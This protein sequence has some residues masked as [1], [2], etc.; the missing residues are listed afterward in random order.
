MMLPMIKQEERPLSTPAKRPSLE[1]ADIFRLYGAE[2]RAGHRLSSKQRSVMFDIEHCRSEVFG[3]HA[4]ACDEC[5]HIEIAFNSCRNRHCPRC[6]GIARRKWVEA[7][8]DELLP[9]P[10]YHVVFTLPDEIFLMGL[11]NRELLYNLLFECAA[12]TLQAFAADPKHLGA[13]IGFY[14]ILHTW[15][16]TLWF[17]PHIH[18]IVIGGGLRED[19]EWIRPKYESRFLFPVRA[20]S[21]VFRGKFIEGLKRAYAKGELNFPEEMKETEQGSKF[22][23]WLNRLVSRNWVVYAKAPFAGPEEVV[24][25]IGRYTHRVA[26]SNRRLISID[27]GEVRFS[28]KDYKDGGRRKEMTLSSEEFIRRFLWHVLPGGFHRIRY[29]GFLANG[30][31]K[32]RTDQIR[33]LLACEGEVSRGSE[34]ETLSEETKGIRCPVCRKGRMIPFLV[35]RRWGWALLSEYPFS[36]SEQAW[37]TS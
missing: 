23:G 9:V 37:D 3:Y 28:F 5:G 8:L 35:V 27:N 19:G 13:E 7:R 32:A 17:H 31:R 33:R 14:G 11:Y 24:R 15:G 25:Y 10:Y 22:E 6:Q 12:A 30:R 4:D 2:Y 18:F 34:E 29:Y 36:G 1:L 16:Q 26:I 21:A 20:L